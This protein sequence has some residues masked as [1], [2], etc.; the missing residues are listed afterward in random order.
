MNTECENENLEYCGE[1]EEK[2]MIQLMRLKKIKECL[3][4]QKKEVKL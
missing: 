4:K 1:C 2:T 3:Q